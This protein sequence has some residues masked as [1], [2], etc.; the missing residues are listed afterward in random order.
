MNMG[1]LFNEKVIKKKQELI[2]KKDHSVH[3]KT[4]KTVHTKILGLTV[5]KTRIT[6]LEPHSK[7][8][9]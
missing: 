9:T 2:M 6:Y 3:Q 4:T 1:F 8:S 7:L 5:K